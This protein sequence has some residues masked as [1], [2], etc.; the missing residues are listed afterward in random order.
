RRRRPR[1]DSPRASV[2]RRGLLRRR[3]RPRHPRAP[4]HAGRAF[5]PR[6]PRPQ[7]RPQL[8]RRL[9]RGP[10][11]RPQHDRGP[12]HLPLRSEGLHRTGAGGP[13]RR[14]HRRLLAL[15]PVRVAHLRL[16]RP[17]PERLRPGAAEGV[18]Q[19]HH[20]PDHRRLQRRDDAGQV[21]QPVLPE[22]AAGAGAAGVGPGAGGA[23][24]D[25]A[26]C[27]ALRRQP[28]RLFQG[29]RAR[30]GEGQRAWG[31]DG[32]QGRGPATLRRVQHPLH[33]NNESFHQDSTVDCVVHRRRSFGMERCMKSSCP[34]LY[35]IHL[36]I[37]YT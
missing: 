16:R 11:P 2:P 12:A 1:Q 3:P 7:G 25:E 10:T 28:D 6:P 17:Q 30:H 4:H 14:P 33:L 13:L 26:L 32:P 23:P 34:K 5:L 37:D 35:H 29:L 18:C 9:R 22:P 20:G 27:G 36:Y 21:R 15:R 19:L 8:H 31:E 24:A